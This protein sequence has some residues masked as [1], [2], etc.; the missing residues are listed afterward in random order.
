MSVAEIIQAFGWI[1]VCWLLAVHILIRLGRLPRYGAAV[2]VAGYVAALTIVAAAV[3]T[4]MWP[5]AVLGLL[6]MRT[7]LLGHRHADERDDNRLMTMFERFRRSA[8]DT[9]GE[10]GVPRARR[11]LHEGEE[12]VDDVRIHHGSGTPAHLPGRT[13]ASAATLRA[14]TVPPSHAKD[15]PDFVPASVGLR[16][17]HHD[18]QEENRSGMRFLSSAK[19]FTDL[20]LKVEIIAVVVVA[21]VLFGVWAEGQRRE[22]TRTTNSNVCEMSFSC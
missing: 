16:E 15:D 9:G 8:P 18:H 13:A 11:P 1:P 6:F 14:R 19:H 4:R 12:L 3:S 2:R 17:P 20:V 5:I 22:F 7:E 21:L 10:P